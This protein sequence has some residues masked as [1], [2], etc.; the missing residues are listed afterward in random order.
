MNGTL[1]SSLAG[2]GIALILCATAA[3]SGIAVAIPLL[4]LAAAHL[5]WA[6]ISLRLGRI[7]T[8][9]IACSVAAVEVLLAGGMLITGLIGFV[10]FLALAGLSWSVAA[11]AAIA[12]RRGRREA[13]AAPLSRGRRPGAFVLVLVAEALVVAAVTTPAL[14]LSTPGEFALPHGESHQGH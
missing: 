12:R 7:A 8:P 13:P 2:V 10:P 9:R 1:W 11:V 5:G 3:G 4:V 14:A 6:V